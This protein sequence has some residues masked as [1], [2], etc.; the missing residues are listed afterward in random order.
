MR[1]PVEFFPS[2]QSRVGR[3]IRLPLRLVPRGA[4][5][6]ILSG[7][8]AG[9]RW[10]NGSGPGSCWLGIFEL[11][12]RRLFGGFVKPG[13]VVFDVGAH[14][15]S[16]TMHASRLCGSHGHVFAFEPVPANL[17][18][19]K[20]HIELNHLTNVTVIEAA[21]SDIDGPARFA[22]APDGVTSHLSPK[23]ALEVSC[24]RLDTLVSEGIVPAPDCIKIDVE[25]A[26]A[27]V[28]R[29]AIELLTTCRPA[30]FLATHGAHLIEECT[31]I[32]DEVSY[33]LH[34]IAD[35]PD[36]FIARPA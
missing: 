10:I 19:L 25:G 13:M 28:L 5:L 3:L 29:G 2:S 23:G 1:D 34:R 7:P 9:M 18:Y 11:E 24:H 35:L 20:R 31:S 26:E 12:K 32:L 4:V 16:Y 15:G 30:I 33:Q 17:R 36:E 6:P 8:C 14:V 27:A 22:P 21:L